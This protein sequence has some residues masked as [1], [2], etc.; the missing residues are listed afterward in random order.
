M[1][2]RTCERSWQVDERHPLHYPLAAATAAKCVVRC[3]PRSKRKV[4][5]E[6]GRGATWPP[7]VA[8]WP[9]PTSP[10]T[11]TCGR[12][13]AFVVACAVA[14]VV[15]CVVGCVVGCVVAC[16]VGCVVACEGKR[17]SERARG[18]RV[19]EGTG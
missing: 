9:P 19:G 18:R 2:T 10:P 8:T 17:G 16:V 14:C 15:A 7:A 11:S 1:R 6:D 4:E 12:V 5:V 13:A 3:S